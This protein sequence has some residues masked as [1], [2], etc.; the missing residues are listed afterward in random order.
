MLVAMLMPILAYLGKLLFASLAVL[1]KVG[2][3]D[4]ALVYMR[5]SSFSMF[6]TYTAIV[7]LAAAVHWR[8]YA[9]RLSALV[10]LASTSGLLIAI[11]MAA[12]S[13]IGISG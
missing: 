7:A 5:S 10:C 8:V 3:G 13:V 9:G 2:W 12:L 11:L 4:Y 1:Y 6:I